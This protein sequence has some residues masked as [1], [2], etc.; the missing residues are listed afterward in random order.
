MGIRMK[1]MK[2]IVVSLGLCAVMAVVP[3]GA[4][5]AQDVNEDGAEID[6]QESV[7]YDLEKGGTQSFEIVDEDGEETEII[8]EEVP[9]KVRVASKT[10]KI[11]G[12]YREKWTAGFYI[13]VNNN[14]ITR[15]HDKFYKVTKGSISNMRLLKESDAQ[16]TLSFKYSFATVKKNSKVVAKILN[17]R[18]I[19]KSS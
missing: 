4:V 8:V 12:R 2:R 16:A 10:Y 1:E 5:N 15:A 14:R 6:I 7:E 18:L 9:G 11:T 13:D 3:A 19:V 17:K